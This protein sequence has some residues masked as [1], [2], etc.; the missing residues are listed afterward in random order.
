MAALSVSDRQRVYRGL[1]RLWSRDGVTCDFSKA[2]LYDPVGN[3]GVV[4]E[5]DDWIDGHSGLTGDTIGYNGALN[6]T[7]RA[8]LT[9][10]M[11]TDLFLAVAA[12]RRGL[13]YVRRVLG[14]VD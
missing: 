6:V 11:K 4:A 2:Q 10:D 7:M 5:T 9:I 14:E 1:M 3:T 8:A 13:D 12:M